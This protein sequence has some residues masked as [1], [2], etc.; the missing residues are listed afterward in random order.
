MKRL[1]L[2]SGARVAVWLAAVLVLAAPAISLAAGETYYWGD[3][4]HTQIV[5]SGGIYSSATTFK[6]AGSSSTG[7]VTSFNATLPTACPNSAPLNLQLTLNQSDLSPPATTTPA[8]VSANGC[9]STADTSVTVSKDQSAAQASGTAA[10]SSPTCTAPGGLSWALCPVYN[11]ILS[12]IQKI[13]QD[14]ITPFLVISPIPVGQTNAPSYQIWLQVR[15]LADVFFIIAFL[16]IIF[17]NTLS[18]GLDSYTLKKTL[19]R[20]V[21]AAI[22]VQ[23]S[24]VLVALAVDV[25]NIIGAGLGSLILSPLA[26]HT[27]VHF[28]IATGTGL[29]AGGVAAGIALAFA[30]AGAVMTG[31]ILIILIGA[32]FTMIA[33]FLTLVARQILVTFLLII[34]PLAIAC[35][36]LPN[37]EHLFKL[38]HKSLTRL[39][40]MYPLIV[41]LLASGKVFAVVT[42]AGSGGGA[43]NGSLRSLISVIANIVPLFLIPLTFKYAGSALNGIGNLIGTLTNQAKTKTQGSDFHE[44]YKARVQQRRTELAAGQKLKGFG[45]VTGNRVAAQAGRGVLNPSGY[46]TG[47]NV[48]AM[49]AFNKDANDWKKRLEDENFGYEG[50]TYLSQGEPW[51]TKTRGDINKKLTTARNTGDSNGVALQTEALEKLE[52]GRDQARLYFGNSAARAAAMLKRSEI[53]VLG[54][55]DREEIPN[56]TLKTEAGQFVA[57]Q[58]WGRA[59]EGARKTSVHLAYTDLKGNLDTEELQKYVSKKSQGTWVEYSVD[60]IKA[61]K[62]AKILHRLAEQQ[63]TRQVLINIMSHTGGPSIGAEQQVLIKEVLKD[64]SVKNPGGVKN[65]ITPDDQNSS[66]DG[67]GE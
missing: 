14:V 5:G 25:T 27:S 21:Y 15:N 53:E 28:D 50:L 59:K 45:L 52:R 54:P 32:F 9:S 29:A 57:R 49:V 63:E 55:E 40:L 20:L 46:G 4:G 33:V 62:D 67:D 38:W 65:D 3:S 35:W 51:Y 42:L 6:P 47:A 36:I 43:A 39:L 22:L 1:S 16:V 64:R 34:A 12:S 48:R 41:L 56:Y 26:G 60:A 2:K 11:F 8:T 7:A 10:A 30:A 17:A 18:I 24:F 19:P 37:T 58:L 23:F 66:N 61:M 44:R 13:E 31:S